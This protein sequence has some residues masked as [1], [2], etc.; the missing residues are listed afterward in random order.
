MIS[1]FVKQHTIE[2]E[3]PESKHKNHNNNIKVTQKKNAKSTHLIS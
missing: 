2:P 1:L 3:E